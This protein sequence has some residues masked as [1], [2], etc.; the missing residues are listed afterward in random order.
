M[1]SKLQKYLAL[2]VIGLVGVMIVVK[3]AVNYQ[4]NKIVWKDSDRKVLSSDCLDDLGGY[5]VRFPTASEEYCACTT[6]AIMKEYKKFEYYTILNNG[7]QVQKEEML[8]AISPCYNDFQ[9]AMFDES[10]L[11]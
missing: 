9:Q 8:S 4:S 2:G 10:K 7:D 1:V 3:L 5:A 11:D 6:D